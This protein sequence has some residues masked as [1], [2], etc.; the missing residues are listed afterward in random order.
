MN[1]QVSKLIKDKEFLIKALEKDI[2][3]ISTEQS[4]NAINK[5]ICYEKDLIEKLKNCL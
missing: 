2:K 4:Y 1:K 5:I 3:N